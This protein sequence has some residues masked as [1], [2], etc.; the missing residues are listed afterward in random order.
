MTVGIV[1]LG[2]IGGSIAKAIKCYTDEHVLATDIDESIIKLAVLVNAVD[3][4][5]CKENLN[6]CD[7]VFISLYPS[8]AVKFVQENRR[9]FKKGAVVVDCCG[10]KRFICDKCFDIARQNNFVFIGGHPMAGFHKSGF[11]HSRE[12]LFKNAAMILVPEDTKNIYLFENLKGLLNKI[13]FTVVTVT[14]AQ[15]HDKNIAFTSQLA[16]VVSNAYVKSPQARLHKGFSAG[17]YKDL[18]RVAR[19]NEKMWSE[20]FLENKDFLKSEIDNLIVQLGKYSQALDSE[21]AKQLEQ[22]LREGRECKE[23]IDR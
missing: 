22:L 17:S 1:G 21:D 19:L 7:Y 13:G 10:V 18:T 8:D 3:G 15:E 4:K 23:R 2:L 20:L 16:H 9:N 14:S 12:T 5:L 11:K 6:E